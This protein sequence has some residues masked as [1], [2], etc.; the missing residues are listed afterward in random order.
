MNANISFQLLSHAKQNQRT[1]HVLTKRYVKDQP[2][3][4]FLLEENKNLISFTSQMLNLQNETFLNGL[5][6]LSARKVNTI[7]SSNIVYIFYLY[8]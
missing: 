8:Q 4:M 2:T 3:Q 7:K 5:D 1:N 6:K